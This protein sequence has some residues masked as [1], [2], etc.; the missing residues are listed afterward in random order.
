MG[1]P[2]K[3]VLAIVNILPF[4]YA[5]LVSQNRP[6]RYRFYFDDVTLMLQLHPGLIASW[7]DR[8]IPQK[9]DPTKALQAFIKLGLP[10]YDIDFTMIL[11]KVQKSNSW[12]KGSL[13]TIYK[14]SAPFQVVIAG[15][16][17]P[18]TVL[19][20]PRKTDHSVRLRIK[21][22][23]LRPWEVDSAESHGCFRGRSLEIFIFQ[24]DVYIHQT[25][26]MRETWCMW[27]FLWPSPNLVRLAYASSEKGLRLG[28]SSHVKVQD[29]TATCVS[30]SGIHGPVMPTRTVQ[31]PYWSSWT[32]ANCWSRWTMATR[33]SLM[34]GH[35]RWLVQ[36]TSKEFQALHFEIKVSR[37]Q[38]DTLEIDC[39]IFRQWDFA[40]SWWRAPCSCEGSGAV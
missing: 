13:S 15:I 32:Q 17:E 28:L 23:R 9:L 3:V 24:T 19:L 22:T 40:P 2:Q 21:P 20:I 30:L 4:I 26:A 10:C 8:V 38:R 5:P 12:G 37:H 39:K 35:A 25:G 16:S 18:S 14:V 31:P 36:A 34:R 6:N 11:L 7:R 29:C 27:W 33:R 1:I